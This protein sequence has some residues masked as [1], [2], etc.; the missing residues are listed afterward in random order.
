MSRAKAPEKQQKTLAE[1]PVPWTDTVLDGF[2]NRTL[3]S[4]STISIEALK[5]AQMLV[6]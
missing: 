3:V 5:C 6:S 1:S 4:Q 2:Q